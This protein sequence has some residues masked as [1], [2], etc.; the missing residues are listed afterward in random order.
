MKLTPETYSHEYDYISQE[1]ISQETMDFPPNFISLAATLMNEQKGR[2]LVNGD[3]P[4]EFEVNEWNR[5]LTGR[6]D[7]G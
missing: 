6:P 2:V 1:Y 5:L 3:L 4:P 7:P